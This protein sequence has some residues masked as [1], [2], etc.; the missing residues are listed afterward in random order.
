MDPEIQ[1]KIKITEATRLRTKKDVKKRE[2]FSFH[3]ENILRMENN[4]HKKN[5]ETKR[6]GRNRTRMKKKLH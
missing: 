2:I 3:A 6:G 1:L 4:M 5:D